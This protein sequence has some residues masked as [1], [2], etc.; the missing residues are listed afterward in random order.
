MKLLRLKPK[1]RQRE[2]EMQ[3]A[4]FKWAALAAATMPELRLLFAIPNGF[5]GAVR[6]RKDGTKFCSS[7][8]KM[9]GEGLKSGVPDVCL[10]VA[11]GEFHGLWLELKAG[12]NTT[13][14]TQ[15]EWMGALTAQ[16]HAVHLVRNEWTHA[17][18]IIEE[19]LKGEH[20]EAREV[21]K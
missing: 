12:D 11:R 14:P 20:S 13:S 1:R 16:G 21:G 10:P 15:R 7:K 17:V 5:S 6:T 19:Y 18:R 2:R 4:L 3:V 9:V 8:A